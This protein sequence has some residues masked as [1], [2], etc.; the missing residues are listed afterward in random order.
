MITTLKDSMLRNALMI[1]HGTIILLTNNYNNSKLTF[2]ELGN[3]NPLI[4]LLGF[5]LNNKIYFKKQIKNLKKMSY[6]ENVSFLHKSMKTVIKI[7]YHKFRIKKKL[8]ISK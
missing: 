1:T 8:S 2:K 6:I 7:P 3:I 4:S 5:G